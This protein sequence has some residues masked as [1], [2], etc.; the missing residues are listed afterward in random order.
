[1]EVDTKYLIIF[2]G[3]SATGKTTLAKNVK[4]TLKSKTKG[5]RYFA[6]D[7]YKQMLYESYGFYN[8]LERKVLWNLAK[9]MFQIDIIKEMRKSNILIID[10]AFD[11]SWNTY[12]NSVAQTY[13]YKRVVVNFNTRTFEDIWQ[14]RVERDSSNERPRCLTAS[15]Y[16]IGEVYK[17][18]NKLNSE[19]KEIKRKEYEV[20]KYT[21]IMGD[22]V[23][24]DK[25]FK[26]KIE[27]LKN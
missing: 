5:V 8:E 21:R 13:G 26:D 2:T 12:F 14:S 3:M 10:Y 19:Y 6:L 18:N 27:T 25:E 7:N 24:S 15:A 23:Y 11:E 9:H 22:I 20:G 4:D 1:M 17:S 16:V